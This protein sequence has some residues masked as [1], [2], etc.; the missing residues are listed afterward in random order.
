MYFVMYLLA[1]K[2]C[3][4]FVG[5]LEEG[6]STIAGGACAA[7]GF[8]CVTSREFVATRCCSAP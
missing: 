3:H 7:V 8:F 5:F 2:Y 4:R 1:P 6:A